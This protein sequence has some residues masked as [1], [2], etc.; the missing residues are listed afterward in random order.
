MGQNG[1]E[2][3]DEP[4]ALVW[5]HLLELPS[6]SV[7]VVYLDL[8]HWISLAQ[9]SVGHSAG[10][11]FARA[12]EACRAARSSGTA[13]FVLSSTHY[14]EI[15][16]I[17]DPEQRRA[18]A[19]IMEE[20]TGFETLVSRDVVMELELAAMLDRFA[21]EPSP[22]PMTA[23]IGRGVRH[24]FGLQSGLKIMGP[25]GD[26]TDQ[27]RERMGAE[28]F[29]DFVAQANLGLERP[30]LR[31][32]TDKEV[33]GLRKRGWNPE[34]AMQVAETRAAEERELR[35]QFDADN[36]W[37]RGRLRDVVA[38]RELTIEFRDMFPRALK[39]RGLMQA[40]VLQDIQ[41]ARAFVRGM[42]STEVAIELKTAWHRN[43]DKH[44]TMND[45]QDIDAMS[46]AVPYCDIVVTEKACHHALGAARLGKRM[47]TALLRNLEDLPSS[48]VQWKPKRAPAD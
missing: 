41:S 8:N 17:K 16:K 23:L 14:F 26:E 29:D 1:H 6:D 46:L 19:D 44:W 20:L 5:P 3:R 36:Q 40:D 7:N 9:T 11:S 30:L 32:P 37:R 39:E 4:P 25:S 35:L 43:R 21:R 12:L 13:A 45:I 15:S 42:P 18:L 22:L 24:A 28:A 10:R 34:A 48:L 47:H 38:A 31:G 33:E 2:M 27:V